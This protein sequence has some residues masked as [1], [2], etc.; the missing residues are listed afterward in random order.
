MR[1]RIDGYL[2]KKAQNYDAAALVLCRYLDDGTED[3]ILRREGEPELGL[4]DAFWKA[5]DGVVAWGKSHKA[6]ALARGGA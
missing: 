2:S 5:R 3:W 1:E 4:G 6:A